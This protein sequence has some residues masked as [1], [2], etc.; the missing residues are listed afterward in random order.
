[1][2]Q[3]GQAAGALN[4]GFGGQVILHLA[5]NGDTLTAA[6]SADKLF[7]SQDDGRHWRPLGGYPAPQTAAERHGEQLYTTN[8]QACHGD[9]GIGESPAPGKTSLA[10]ALDETAHA[11]HH[12]DEQLE[13]V[14]LEGL[15]SPSRM[16]AWSGTLT[17]TDARDLIAYMKS[18]WDARALRC[19]GPKH[20][21]P[22]CRR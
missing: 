2:A 4:N 1:M 18:L 13:K 10:P 12:T 14:I 5:R 22:E 6:T 15:P 11:W 19:Q 7:V 9:H 3:S 16:P 20:M 21:S 17:P 8:C